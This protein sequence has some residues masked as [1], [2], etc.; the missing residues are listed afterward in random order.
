MYYNIHL[1]LDARA[2][3]RSQESEALSV[4]QTLI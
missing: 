4:P 3:L 2:R 1:I